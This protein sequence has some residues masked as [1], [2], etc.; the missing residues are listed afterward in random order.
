MAA[1]KYLSQSGGQITE[2]QA[3]DSSAGVTDAGKIIAADSTGRIDTSFMPVGIT[4]EVKILVASEAL[5]I[6]N[7]VNIYDDSGT[8]K[9]RKADGSNG[10]RANGFVLA[11]VN[12]GANATVYLEGTI[13]GLSGK[14]P[15]APQY[16][17]ADTAGTMVET[18]DAGAGE[19][20]QEVGVAISPTEVS[21]EPQQPIT[22]A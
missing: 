9:A 8:E 22:L 7:L 11:A 10:R 3:K 17:S 6:R 18:P 14:T 21:F 5:T 1:N 2:V 4:P 16:L 15:G 20:S 13:T 12:L 19:I